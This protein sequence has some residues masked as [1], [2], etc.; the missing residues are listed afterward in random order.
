MPN[1]GISLNVPA[2]WSKASSSEWIS[3][4][5]ADEKASVDV[6]VTS[7][8]DGDTVDQWANREKTYMSNTFLP[9]Y[10]QIEP[11]SDVKVSDISAKQLKYAYN[12]GD[13]AKKHTV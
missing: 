11:I 8:V 7:A 9:S 12:Y 5:N 1:S 6:R 10:I 3:L 2:T 13:A 4:Y